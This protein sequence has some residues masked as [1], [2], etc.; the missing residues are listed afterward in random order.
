[1]VFT[2]EN[3]GTLPETQY[4]ASSRIRARMSA[5]FPVEKTR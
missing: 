2:P 3:P 4:V 5:T 1:L